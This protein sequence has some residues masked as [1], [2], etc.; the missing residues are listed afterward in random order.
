LARR[1]ALVF[2]LSSCAL[3]ALYYFPY[4]EGSWMKHE[5]AGYLRAYAATA[6]A[7][8]R[9][10]D[11]SVVVRGQDIVGRYGLRIARTCDAMDV[12]I[13]FVC[14]VLAWP[15][16]WR[17]RALVAAGGAAALFVVN[18][19]RICSLYYVGLWRPSWFEFVHLELWPAV[20]VIAAVAAFAAFAI[21]T[22]RTEAPP[23]VT[24]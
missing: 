13:L 19:A 10:F 16:E 11:P 24:A 1:F 12:Q 4:P 6:G 22:R 2:A 8:L 5:L 20:I 21:W 14:A 3:L 17:V 9:W 7:V 18:V 23:T 15:T